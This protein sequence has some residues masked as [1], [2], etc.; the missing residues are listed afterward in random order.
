M[1]LNSF[2]TL[3]T[4][5]QLLNDRKQMVNKYTSISSITGKLR[6]VEIVL[7]KLD[8]RLIISNDNKV[9]NFFR[10]DLFYL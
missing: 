10:I 5:T 6:L 3:H 1:T 2:L 8:L 4:H 9:L 7:V